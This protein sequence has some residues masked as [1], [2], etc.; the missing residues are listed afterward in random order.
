MPPAPLEHQQMRIPEVTRA[1]EVRAPHHFDPQVE[2][3][4]RGWPFGLEIQ[5]LDDVDRLEQRDSAGARRR[6]PDNVG[7]AGSDSR[8]GTRSLRGEQATRRSSFVMIPPF[9]FMSSAMRLAIPTRCR[10]RLGA[11]C[12]GDGAQRRGEI[13]LDQQIA[14][15]SSRH[16]Q[17]LQR[18]RSMNQEHTHRAQHLAVQASSEVRRDR[19]AISQQNSGAKTTCFHKSLPNFLCAS[20]RTSRRCLAPPG[21]EVCRVGQAALD[22]AIH[23]EV[24]RLRRFERGFP[25]SRTR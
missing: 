9:A 12:V 13:G 17:V 3:R 5:R 2:S 8:T 6:H 1:I 24:G 15:L 11:N 22:L 23:T 10:A 7:V 14:A 20:S 21:R 25:A 4:R 19:E 16:C 18:R